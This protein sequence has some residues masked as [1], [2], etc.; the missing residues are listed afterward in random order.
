MSK[1]NTGYSLYCK[2]T[3]YNNLR[4]ARFFFNQ[5]SSLQ[6]FDIPVNFLKQF[7]WSFLSVVF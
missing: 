3:G 6:Q 7:F 4:F 1:N 2:D 5:S